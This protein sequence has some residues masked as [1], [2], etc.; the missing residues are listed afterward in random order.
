VVLR[1]GVGGSG[2]GEARH[3]MVRSDVGH[4]PRGRSVG[5]R[6]SGNPEKGTLFGGD[7]WAGR[8][9]DRETASIWL[10]NRVYGACLGWRRPSWGENVC[11]LCVRES[12]VDGRM[13]RLG[14][15]PAG[16]ACDLPWSLSTGPIPLSVLRGLP[17]IVST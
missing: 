3:E 12:S 15:R 5:S 13:T 10:E 11:C 2:V 4:R 7:G 16:K 8:C 1:E 9:T 17:S 14:A 6:A